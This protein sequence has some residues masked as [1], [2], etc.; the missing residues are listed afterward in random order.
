[1][2]AMRRSMSKRDLDWG[3][4]AVL[5]AF[6]GARVA[7]AADAAVPDRTVNVPAFAL[8]PS[9]YLSPEAKAALSRPGIDGDDMLAKVLSSGKA[10]DLRARM[11]QLMAKQIGHLLD[12]YPVTIE[13]SVIAGVPAVTATPKAGIPAANRRKILLDLPGGG[14]VMG[15][16]GSTGMTE[17]IP[18]AVM[19]GVRIVSITYR[20]AP[21]ATFPAASE[22]VAAVYRELLK[23][24][25]PQDIGIYGC[26]AGGMLTAEAIAWFQKEKLPLPGATGIFCASAD[27]RQ[28]GDSAVLERP[29]LG[30]PARPPAKRSYFGE[31]DRADPLVSPIVSPDVLRR[32]PPTLIVTATRAHEMSGAVETARRLRELGVDCDLAVWDGLGHAFFYSIDMPE[33]R[34]AFS[35]MA[36]FFRRHLD[37]APTKSG[38][39]TDRRAN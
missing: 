15:E 9:G 22:D 7:F 24:H 26:S 29:L 5:M 13:K 10:G 33:S 39:G 8:P 30:L 14:F 35:V 37:L 18:L 23:T 34:E 27:A 2:M 32:F 16:A 36:A 20:Q 4:T 11:P 21:E 31:H 6:A 1:M 38:S 12:L 17:A 25:R 3:M 28:L 19:A